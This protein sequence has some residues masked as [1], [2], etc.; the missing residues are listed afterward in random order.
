[1]L[2]FSYPGADPENQVALTPL[3]LKYILK[4]ERGGSYPT[5]DMTSIKSHDSMT[6]THR[7]L[8]EN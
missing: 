6:Y 1:M 2:V 7:S 4:L 5:L 8:Q 3:T